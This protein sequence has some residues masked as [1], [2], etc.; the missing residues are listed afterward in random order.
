MALIAS[1]THDIG[2]AVIDAECRGE[3]L[4]VMACSAIGGGYQVINRGRLAG[5]INAVGIVMAAVTGQFRGVDQAVIEYSIETEVGDAVA[6]AAI[7]GRR[8]DSRHRRMAGRRVTD[9]VIG[10][11]AMAGIAPVSDNGGA[12]VVGEGFLKTFRRVAVNAISAGNRMGSRG[13]VAGVG[14]FADG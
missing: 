13:I 4:G 1:V 12:A 8:I 7:D 3:S 2:T 14:R 10:K 9:V 6:V 11:C 5:R